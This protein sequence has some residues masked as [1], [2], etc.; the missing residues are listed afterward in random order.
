MATHPDPGQFVKELITEESA[1]T[2]YLVEEVLNTH[3]PEVRELLLSTSILERVNAEA[4]C[5]LAGN[6]TGWPNPDGFGARQRVRPA[7]RGRV[8]S[9]PHAVRGG[10]APQAEAAS[11]PDR[12]ASLHRRAARWYERHGQLT[13]AVRHATEA[14]DWRLAAS[15][16]IDELAISEIIEPRGIPSLADEFASMPPGGS[17]DRTGASPGLR[18][19]RAVR[20][21]A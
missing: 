1:L 16:V 2:G 17:L 8:V 20:R 14:G 13:D 6:A 3:P 5:D 12:I 18:R 15:M 11:D 19:G 4:A 9:L 21:P 7:D 10:A